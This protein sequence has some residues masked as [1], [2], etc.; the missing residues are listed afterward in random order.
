VP[1]SLLP[2]HPPPPPSFRTE[3]AD[4]SSPFAPA[5][6]DSDPVGNASVCAERPPPHPAQFADEISLLFAFHRPPPASA[7]LPLV[8]H[9]RILRL[10][11]TPTSARNSI[12][13]KF[14]RLQRDSRSVVH[15]PFL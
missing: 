14:R 13:S 4:F 5:I 2:R 7:S 8:L 15:G 10:T 3:Q 12:I 6:E 9:R 1:P 11:L